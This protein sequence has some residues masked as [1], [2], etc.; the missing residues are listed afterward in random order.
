MNTRAPATPYNPGFDPARG[1]AATPALPRPA[2][3]AIGRRTLGQFGVLVAAGCSPAGVLNGLAP[4]RLVAEGVPYADGPRHKLDVYA[5]AAPADAAPIVVFLYGGGWKAGD[6]ATYRFVG[7]AMAEAGAIVV[8][9][10]YRLYPEVRYPGFL[11][12]CA[13]ALRWA[14]DNAAAYATPRNRL[15]A[16]RGEPGSE[17]LASGA[18]QPRPVFV[19]GHSAGAYN[20]AMLAL[21]RRWLGEVGLEPRYALRGLIGLSGPYDFLPLVDPQLVT[22]FGGADR[23]DTQPISYVGPE[24][25]PPAFLATGSADTTVRPANTQHLAER[26]RACG[27]FVEERI[28]PGINHVEIIGA[29]ANPLHFVAPVLRDTLGFIGLGAAPAAP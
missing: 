7:G 4:R 28:Y 26:L 10:D 3:H 19:M 12:D 21:D 9:P 11:Q 13:G 8:I 1:S 18:A 29:V 25:G 23:I 16:Q 5:P 6:R 15:P 17:P 24:A 14:H 22:M 20:A 27:G 2:V